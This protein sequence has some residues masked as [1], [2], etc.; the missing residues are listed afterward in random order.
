MIAIDITLRDILCVIIG[1]ILTT[2]ASDTLV[3]DIILRFFK[4]VIKFVIKLFFWGHFNNNMMT[5]SSGLSKFYDINR[6]EQSRMTMNCDINTYWMNFGY[7]KKE[8][9]ETNGT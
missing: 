2:F 1:C 9:N 5:D 6:Y 8:N 7:W 4:V 3:G